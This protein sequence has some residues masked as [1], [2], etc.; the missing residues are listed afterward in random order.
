MK[1]AIRNLMM[2]AMAVLLTVGCGKEKYTITVTANPTAYGIVNGS[3]EYEDG[4]T[5][6]LSAVPNIG[7]RFVNWNDGVT[8]NPRTVTVTGDAVYVANFATIGDDPN[9]NPGPGPNP[10]PAGDPSIHVAF[11]DQEWDGVAIIQMDVSATMGKPAFELVVVQDQNL[12]QSVAQFIIP[13]AE[14]SYQC[15][16]AN[17]DRYQAFYFE[18]GYD[19]MVTVNEQEVP[20][21]M[22]FNEQCSGT[23]T[24]LDLNA[25]T[26]S[27]T[28]NATLSN[29][30]N[31][32]NGL[33]EETRPL[34][35]T[36]ENV[37]YYPNPMG[38]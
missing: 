28:M 29:M 6:T 32:A 11:G 2:L 35:I 37:M 23:I 34:S 24:A 20:R 21:W 36:L 19:D 13:A 17:G 22:T 26:I 12:A 4:A 9:P 14:G 7:Y 31:V 38:K 8:D 3:G 15:N 16:T 1:K 30:Y 25:N 18:N 27:L 5:V 10:G 33:E